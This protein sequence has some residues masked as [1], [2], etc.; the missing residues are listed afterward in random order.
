[1]TDAAADTTATPSDDRDT[2]RSTAALAIATVVALG[3][4][5][6]SWGDAVADGW[7]QH[8]G[9]GLDVHE[10]VN[11]ALMALFFLAVGIELKREL[12]SGTLR[13]PRH[14]AVPVAAALG[15]MVLP[16]LIYLSI[17]A[18]TPDVRGW[19]VPM[20]TDV[21]FALGVLILVA[22]RAPPALRV[23]LLSL[24]VVDDL[25][26]IIVIAVAYSGPI[27][28]GWCA[29]GLATAVLLWDLQRRGLGGA[30]VPVVAAAVIWVCLFRSGVHATIAGVLV[31]FA[32]SEQL[33]HRWEASLDR[34]VRW[35]V[36][37][38]FAF[39]NAGV[40]IAGPSGG[41]TNWSVIAAVAVALV[42]GKPLGII[43][44]TWIAVRFGGGSLPAAVTWRQIGGVGALGGM[45]FTVALL[46][47]DLAFASGSASGTAA[48]LA[49]VG[50][51]VVAAAIGATLLRSRPGDT[52][53]KAT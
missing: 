23:F 32:L 26:A 43:V 40:V 49:V 45:G 35:I 44:A 41:S 47:A 12:R 52:L 48:R 7:R 46:V 34:V 1:M 37:P 11:D 29:G 38:V 3:L 8:V 25:G 17:T 19:G 33:G 4:A 53:G 50:S 39:A 42:V 22:R 20:A 6:S 30:A 16:A 5:N 36:L 9:F 18:G 27:G 2:V 24:A 51:S 31:G 15:G 21:A 28:W 14:A 13:D 10:V